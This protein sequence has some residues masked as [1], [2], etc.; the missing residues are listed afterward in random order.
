MKRRS[1]F[2]TNSSSSSFLV[3]YKDFTGIDADT[4][5]KYPFLANIQNIIDTIIYVDGDYSE[6]R[7]GEIY[8]S[9]K[10]WIEYLL[11]NYYCKSVEELLKNYDNRL[12]EKISAYFDK[13]YKVFEKWV[14]Y[15]DES[16]STIIRALDDGENF[17]VLDGD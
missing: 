9:R 4:L 12:Y 13:G 6:T 16:L 15:N 8:T 14:D 17:I 5:S 10:E 2:V 7:P 3:A 11:E 1:D